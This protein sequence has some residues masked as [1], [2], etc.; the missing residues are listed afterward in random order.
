LNRATP[1]R[2]QAVF[3]SFGWRREKIC[4]VGANLASEPTTH[5]ADLQGF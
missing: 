5:H 1:D 3:D 4:V 2:F